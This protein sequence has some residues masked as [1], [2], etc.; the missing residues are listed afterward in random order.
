MISR[1]VEDP[2]HEL[3]ETLNHS[4]TGLCLKITTLSLTDKVKH[5]HLGLVDGGLDL[6]HSIMIGDCIDD[7]DTET[8]LEN[9]VVD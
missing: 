5:L 4:T 3:L 1:R 7:A 9:P 6:A 8:A 2:V